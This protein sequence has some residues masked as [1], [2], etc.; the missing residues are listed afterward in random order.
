MF[1][2]T[3]LG[4]SA[5]I[6]SAD[7]NH[8]GLLISL[9]ATRVLVDCGEGTQRQ[10]LIAGAG[11]RHLHRLLLTHDHFDHVLGIPGLLATLGVQ[12]KRD[13]LV[14]NGGARTLEAVAQILAGFWGPGRAPV[15]IEFAPVEANQQIAMDGFTVTCFPIRHRDTDSFGYSFEIAPRRHLR[16]DRLSALAIPDGPIRGRLAAG[17]PVTLSSGET[18]DPE[19]VLGP[20]EDGHK[21]VV[22]GDA[23]T[24]EGL[25]KIVRSANLLVIEATFL[26]RD[27]AIARDYGHLTAA[28]AARLAAHNG[29]HRLILTHLSG[30]YEADEILAEASSIFSATSI[31]SDFDRV[32]V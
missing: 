12:N 21:L 1:E 28:E 4:T 8:P 13:A 6:P 20:P 30:R 5:S 9:G 11:F 17:L 32:T 14:V 22:I 3:F 24:T 18:I 27:A 31:A 15:A 23:E 29:V 19:D 2:L 16:A 10:L 26:E 7:R 25:E